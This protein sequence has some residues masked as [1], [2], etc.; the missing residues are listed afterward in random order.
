[1]LIFQGLTF[2]PHFELVCF[3]VNF[4]LEVVLGLTW[5]CVCF[6]VIF[7]GLYPFVNPYLF[8]IW[9]EY[10]KGTFSRHRKNSQIKETLFVAQQRGFP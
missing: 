7:Y 9:G 8:F 2:M 10:F 3:L 5:I 6:L 1:M 4:P